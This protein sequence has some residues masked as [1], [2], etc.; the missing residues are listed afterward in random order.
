MTPVPENIS[1]KA[2]KCSHCFLV[3]KILCCVLTNKEIDGE[4]M[5]QSY[6]LQSVLWMGA[7]CSLVPSTGLLEV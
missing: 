2:V 1:S 5:S 6:T 4:A 7:D 3:N